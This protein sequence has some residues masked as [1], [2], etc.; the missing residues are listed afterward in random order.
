M[1][2]EAAA[3]SP[4][5]AGDRQAFGSPAVEL[6]NQE[7]CPVYVQPSSKLV[8]RGGGGDSYSRASTIHSGPASCIGLAT[9]SHALP[10]QL[11]GNSL[12]SKAG[13][14]KP[15]RW[16]HGRVKPMLNNSPTF[17]LPFAAIISSL[18]YCYTFRRA[19]QVAA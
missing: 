17:Y 19:K 2:F 18:A 11:A 9:H 12:I 3:F 16:L 10:N 6:L 5:L 8:R 13:F 15:V 7:Q 1:W 14:P 4:C